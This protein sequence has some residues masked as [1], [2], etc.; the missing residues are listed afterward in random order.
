MRKL[1]L[2]LILTFTL[3][4]RDY[5]AKVINVI[6]GDTIEV[7]IDLGLD[8]TKKER[9]RL[10]N[11]RA[12][13]TRTKDLEE[14][15]KGLK[16]KAILS[17]KILNKEII[18]RTDNDKREKYGRLLGVILLQELNINTWLIKEGHCLEGTAKGQN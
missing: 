15:A 17:E 7:L 14:K 13:E 16:V 12:P 10:L 6:D 9:I 8:T 4:A 11:V 3:S 1:L 18:L 2:V 5:P